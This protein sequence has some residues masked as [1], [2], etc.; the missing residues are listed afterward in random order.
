MKPITL[1]IAGLHSFREEQEI[2]FGQLGEL[3]IFGIFGP[4][5]SGKSSILDAMT[6]ALY[7]TVVRAGRRTQ[8]ILNHAEK[9]VKVSFTFA[10]GQG[11]ERRLYRV[12]RRYVRK[13]Q[14]AVS[15]TYSRLVVITDGQEEVIAD[16][17]REV[18]EQIT[19]LL[20][21]REEDF[22][23]A[24]VLP[25]G[26]FAE[27][28]SLG[29][30]ERREM[31]QR[32][33]SLEQY[34]NVLINKINE[35]YRTVE[36]SY[37]EVESEQKGLGNASPAA[38]AAAQSVLAEAK[39]VEVAAL[40]QYKTA[41]QHYRTVNEV[42]GL[43]NE[44][45]NKQSEQVF[46]RRQEG[47]MQEK[48]AALAAAEKAG[49]VTAVLEEFAASQ[50]A[51][52]KA[53]AFKQK[54]WEQV[55]QLTSDSQRLNAAYKEAQQTK[56]K[57]E[58]ELI[59][60]RTKLAAAVTLESE[61]TQL[62]KEVAELTKQQQVRNQACQ[63]AS[64]AAGGKASRS[65]WLTEH[66]KKLEQQLLAATVTADRRS[67]VQECLEA[68]QSLK[69][70]CISAEKIKQ[71]GIARKK[72]YEAIRAAAFQAEEKLHQAEVRLD[73]QEAVEA[74]AAEQQLAAA[75]AQ[76]DQ[77]LASEKQAAASRL[78]NLLTPGKPC[79]VCGS[80]HHPQPAGAGQSTEVDNINFEEEIIAAKERIA[81]LNQTLAEAGR[82]VA[83]ERQSLNG[84]KE[85]AVA[86]AQQRS[87]A[88]N[89]V[90]KIREEYHQAQ[91]AIAIAGNKLTAVLQAV[92][93]DTGKVFS[94][95]EALRMAD[96]LQKNMSQQD[97]LAEGLA[98]QM[99]GYRQERE[100]CQAE[101]DRLQQ[102]VQTGAA[103]L[104]AL[105]A[106]L[107]SLNDLVVAKRRELF[108]VT[109]GTPASQLALLT[110]QELDTIRDEEQQARVAYEQA[111]EAL[112]T[113]E[114]MRARSETSWLEAVKQRDHLQARLTA[115]L[116]EEG[117][118][119]MEAAQTALMPALRQEEYCRQIKVYTETDQRLSAQCEH[120]TSTLKGR[121]VTQAEW[122]QSQALFKQTETSRNAATERRVEADKEWRDLTEKYQRWSELETN[123]LA[124]KE[125]KDCLQALKNLLRGNIFIEFLAQEQMELVAWQASE[126]LKQITQQRY[127]LELGPDGGFLIRDDANGGVRRPV[128]TLSG[129][130][131]FQ[132]SLALALAL[133]AQIQ[134]KGKY[135]LEFFF[136]DEGFGSLDQQAL[137]VAMATL[138]KLHVERLTIGI[139]SHVAELKQRMP[140]RLLLEPAEPAGHGSRVRI[141]EA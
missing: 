61:V 140:R 17:D 68:S 73:E 141:E 128:S 83:K 129:G 57:R 107:Q 78:A 38:V 34:G 88:Q 11:R 22:T 46:H 39:Q 72:H 92:G 117:F 95:T 101:I 87:S 1:T 19:G 124:L 60:R 114:Q 54:I 90:D 29:G 77:L 110:A 7:G 62:D 76:L 113:A 85:A 6:L 84:A 100:A 5:G 42:Y 50:V 55:A 91:E 135:P 16:K 137:D 13:D 89:E 30:K 82:K 36:I 10:L 109:A 20:G 37:I 75:V 97:R 125:R 131:T 119:G 134:L 47:E 70:A 53:A 136:L 27:F 108:T 102:A 63:A 56:L 81:G 94:A 104:A 18:T 132:A 45:A 31:L 96:E 3:G 64:H 121:S 24:V 65:Q 130:E 49:R 21:L 99:T 32:L 28:L 138:E 35:Q 116:E 112:T 111:N 120:L 118:S 139:I 15:N 106:R 4:T 59:E 2:P 126:R 51:E 9:Q 105:T 93:K 14:L 25:Q 33:F 41:E 133:S 74:K 23:R 127:A 52:Q 48:A 115:K 8:G 44:L 12:E 40:E 86:L 103:E 67:Q 26:K 79:P 123:R 69:Q 71:E 98:R 43:Q 122:E 80:L 66:I 58:P